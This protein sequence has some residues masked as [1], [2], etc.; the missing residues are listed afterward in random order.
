MMGDTGGI[1]T[2]L[3]K[4]CQKSNSKHSRKPSMLMLVFKR[5]LRQQVMLVQF[6]QLP[7]QQ[8]L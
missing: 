1:H 5:N 2:A 8:G 4:R 6:W 3:L 7:R